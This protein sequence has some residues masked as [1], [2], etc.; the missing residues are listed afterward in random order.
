MGKKALHSHVTSMTA[1]WSPKKRPLE[2]HQIED[3]TFMKKI[4]ND[5]PWPNYVGEKRATLC[6][7]Y[8][9]KVWCYWE[10]FGD[11]KTLP[12]KTNTIKKASLHD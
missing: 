12:H 4:S 7:A 1:F 11:C 6:K 3:F 9:I 10:H 5:S 8:W 2:D